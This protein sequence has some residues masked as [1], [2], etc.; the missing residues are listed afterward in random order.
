MPVQ[1]LRSQLQAPP[2]EP[3]RGRQYQR[4]G[5]TGDRIRRNPCATGTYAIRQPAGLMAPPNSQ[6]AVP[7]PGSKLPPD[8]HMNQPGPPANVRPGG[9]YGHTSEVLISDGYRPG[10]R[11]LTNHEVLRPSQ[12]AVAGP[13]HTGQLLPGDVRHPLL[14]RHEASI[15]EILGD[16]NAVFSASGMSPRSRSESFS[17]IRDHLRNSLAFPTRF[18]ADSM[19][20]HPLPTGPRSSARFNPDQPMMN[21]VRIQPLRGQYGRPLLPEPQNYQAGLQGPVLR[22]SADSLG[23][24][25]P[26]QQ[27][28]PARPGWQGTMVGPRSAAECGAG[29]VMRQPIANG[30]RGY[31]LPPMVNEQ[32]SPSSLASRTL[33]LGSIGQAQPHSES[34]TTLR[35]NAPAPWHRV[36]ADRHDQQTLECRDRTAGDLPHLNPSASPSMGVVKGAG[37]EAETSHTS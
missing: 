1:V 13:E 5:K 6:Y 8:F 36:N 28:Q 31:T 34:F 21:T 20:R 33:G 3:T 27:V 24:V 15:D 30:P 4:R 19:V 22:S 17:S 12:G 10:T 26:A 35:S 32:G 11:P 29:P 2:C 7:P 37:L 9:G 23:T 18:G 25:S 14:K 16:R